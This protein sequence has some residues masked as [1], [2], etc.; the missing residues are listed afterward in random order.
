MLLEL[1]GRAVSLCRANCS[2]LGKSPIQSVSQR[3]DG[4]LKI[5]ARLIHSL[6]WRLGHTRWYAHELTI[7]GAQIIHWVML[8]RD[9]HTCRT[10]VFMI[11]IVMMKK[12]FAHWWEMNLILRH[13]ETLSRR[14]FS[15]CI[16]QIGIL[17]SVTIHRW[18]MLNHHR[19]GL[20][21]I[22]VPTPAH[23]WWLHGTVHLKLRCW[24]SNVCRNSEYILKVMT[25]ALSRSDFIH[26]YITLLVCCATPR[27]SS[28]PWH[29]IVK[30]FASH[31]KSMWLG[32]HWIERLA[33]QYRVGAM[34]ELIGHK[35]SRWMHWLFKTCTSCRSILQ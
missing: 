8:H 1:S 23:N 34:Y 9:S 18:P 10:S 30:C 27:G 21:I 33:R 7:F 14:I 24:A 28:V 16:H 17:A 3:S 6:T 35:L 5:L 31:L 15:Y 11:I 26:Q 4:L 29:T 32:W 22:R 20:I 12:V 19:H 2:L 13:C 25:T